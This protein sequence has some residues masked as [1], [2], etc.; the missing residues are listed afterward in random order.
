MDMWTFSGQL[1]V[2]ADSGVEQ[3]LAASQPQS[4]LGFIL[5]ATT[6]GTGKP[7]SNS[8]LISGA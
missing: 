1:N 8:H 5:M 7:Q 6:E 2:T 4:H 3:E